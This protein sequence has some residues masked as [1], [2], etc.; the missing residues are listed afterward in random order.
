MLGC[1][2][3]PLRLLDFDAFDIEFLADFRGLA[4]AVAVRTV[5]GEELLG[6]QFAA[7]VAAELRFH[8]LDVAFRALAEGVFGDHIEVDLDGFSH[9]SG[10]V[11]D[12][13]I[14]SQNAL[15]AV[16][17]AMFFGDIDNM[18]CNR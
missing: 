8:G 4:L 12:D 2:G 5:E 14:Y 3:R 15:S 9:I 6:E 13:Q 10:V 16:V 17:A 18:F 11:S 7:F 1:A